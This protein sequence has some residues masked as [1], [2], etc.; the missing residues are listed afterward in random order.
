MDSALIGERVFYNEAC[1]TAVAADSHTWDHPNCGMQ[2]DWTVLLRADDGTLIWAH[3]HDVKMIPKDPAEKPRM[4]DPVMLQ[5]CK[6]LLHAR[7]NIIDIRR[8]RG[9]CPILDQC[10]GHINAAI[11]KFAESIER[12]E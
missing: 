3:A 2:I 7:K 4:K 9:S 11:E 8:Q 1:Y 5:T 12:G 6:M 10:S